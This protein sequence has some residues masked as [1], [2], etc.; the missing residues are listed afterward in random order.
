[1]TVIEIKR[2]MLAHIGKCVHERRKELGISEEELAWRVQ[3]SNCQLRNIEKGI[4]NPKADTL[5]PLCDEL[6]VTIE[7]IY[8]PYAEEVREYV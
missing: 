2:E 4:A 5:V 8:A 6:S 3:I 1:M 7:D